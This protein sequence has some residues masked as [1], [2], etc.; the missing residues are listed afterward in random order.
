MYLEPQRLRTPPQDAVTDAASSGNDKTRDLLTGHVKQ[1]LTEV[2]MSMTRKR[3]RSTTIK[4][5][6]TVRTV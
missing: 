1:E 4:R 2:K 5:C 3:R 6:I